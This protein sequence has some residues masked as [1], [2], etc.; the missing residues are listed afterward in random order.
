MNILYDEYMQLDSREKIPERYKKENLVDLLDVISSK[1]ISSPILSESTR[2]SLVR[3]HDILLSAIEKYNK[4]DQLI[5][6]REAINA[7]EL[8]VAQ[9]V[10]PIASPR[11]IEK[12]SIKE[13]IEEPIYQL[14]IS[15]LKTWVK[16]E[17]EKHFHGEFQENP[18]IESYDQLLIRGLEEFNNSSHKSPTVRSRDGVSPESFF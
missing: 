10:S 16:Q 9:A 11:E 7:F 18:D 2:Q 3:Q 4:S 17:Y 8:R 14:V 1:I 12:P 13:R 6:I 5:R 15:E